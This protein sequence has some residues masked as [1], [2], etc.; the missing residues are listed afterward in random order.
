VLLRTPDLAALPHVRHGFTSRAGGVSEGSLASLNLALRAHETAEALVENW[1]RVAAALDPGLTARSVAVLSQVHGARVVRVE[2]PGG[3]L[4]PV[5][6]ADAAW[7]TEP[8][9]ILAIR[10]ADCVPIVVA[11]AGGVAAIHAGWRGA[12]AG[13][14]PAAIRAF[15]DG[16]GEDPGLMR[17]AVGPFIGPAHFEVGPEVVAALAATGL[18]PGSFSFLGPRGRPHV[19]LGAV[20]HA[21]LRAAG[22]SAIEDLGACTASDPRFWSHRRDGETAGRSAGVVAWR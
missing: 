21:Q 12:A 7:T 9:L 8:G 19:D 18:D 13:V 14:V 11:G 15:A 1:G 4:T 5:A 6:E 3:P 10:V 22:V 20:V 2:A 17:A 16:A